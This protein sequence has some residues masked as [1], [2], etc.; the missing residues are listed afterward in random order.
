MITFEQYLLKQKHLN[1]NK[2]AYLIASFGE[3]KNYINKYDCLRD[4]GITMDDIK[5]MYEYSLS[6][7]KT[8]TEIQ[9]EFKGKPEPFVADY[10]GIPGKFAL[11]RWVVLKKIIDQKKVS[12]KSSV[13][14]NKNNLFAG[15]HD[16]ALKA[17]SQNQQNGK[18]TGWQPS[19][20]D[21]ES[22]ICLA[23]NLKNNALNQNE[24]KDLVEAEKLQ[25]KLADGIIKEDEISES[26]YAKL[27]YLAHKKEIDACVEPLFKNFKQRTG[28]RFD[29]L[30]EKDDSSQIWKEFGKI[31]G[32]EYSPN[33][34]PKTDIISSDNKQRVSCK[35]AKGAQLM[36]G[37]QSESV[38]TII[39]ALYRTFGKYEN[40]PKNIKVFKKQLTNKAWKSIKF[41]TARGVGDLK[42]ATDLTPEEQA[43]LNEL[44]KGEEELSDIKQ[45]LADLIQTNKRFE[46]NLLYEAATG[47]TKFGGEINKVSNAPNVANIVLVWDDKDPAKNEA[48]D[49]SDYIKHI[50]KSGKVKYS[51]SYKTS[52]GRTSISF[53]IQIL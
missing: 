16:T 20:Q 8:K 17:G 22:L 44:R 29:K 50:Q 42:R 12:T 5:A 19:S 6:H 3:A 48:Y 40:W 10:N 2:L 33:N 9:K 41:P 26:D 14:K 45:V 1:E 11:R 49:I 37:A 46:N 4:T 24:Q 18:S 43:T 35:R 51:I 47:N 7:Q 36:S 30:P 13:G 38:A 15:F 31:N 52:S 39:T 32:A 25:E 34:T 23:Y 28:I 27:Y 21:F 53:R